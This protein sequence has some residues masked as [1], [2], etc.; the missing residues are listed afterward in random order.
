LL[1]PGFSPDLLAL[2]KTKN[3]AGDN[4]EAIRWLDKSIAFNPTDSAYMA[5]A[6]VKH[7]LTAGFRDAVKDYTKCMRFKTQYRP[8]ALGE[9]SEVLNRMGHYKELF[10][11]LNA[12]T[13]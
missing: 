4:C 1:L 13:N 6:E 11:G 5:R 10:A 12:L 9:R 8:W 7:I 3:A 2:Y